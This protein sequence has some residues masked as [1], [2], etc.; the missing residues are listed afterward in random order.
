[1]K[2]AILLLAI[3]A[4]MMG[5]KKQ[6][7]VFEFTIKGTITNQESGKFY[8]SESPRLGD[9]IVIHF[10]NYTF[11]YTGTSPYMYSSLI[12]PDYNLQSVFSFLIEPGE[13]IL[14]LDMESLYEKSGVIS[15]DYNLALYEKQQE[16]MSLFMDRDIM[17]DETRAD[18]FLWM[19]ENTDNFT[20]ISFLN[21]W[22]SFEDFMP[23]DQ[24]G[25]FLNHVTDKQLRN[26]KE[27]I[28]L[29]SMWLAKKDNVNAIGNK[30][31]DFR[32]PNSNGDNVGFRSVSKGKLT[33]VEKSGSWCGNTTANSRNLLPVYEKYKDRGL[34]IITVVPELKHDRWLN[35][36]EKE[37]FPWINL[38]ELD[39]NMA[40]RELSY[41]N[42]IFRGGNYLV[43][44]NGIVIATELSSE[45]LNEI[46]MKHFEPEVYE[47]YLSEKWNMPEK[48]QILDKEQPVGSFDELLEALS[49]KPFLIDCWATWCGP[50]F[51]EFKFNEPLKEFLATMNME[52]VYISFDRPEDESKWL[53]TI[54]EHNLKGYHFRFNDSFRDDFAALGFGGG[55]PTYMI[56]NE[57]G[58]VVVNHAY[59]PSQK[60]KLYSQIE[61]VLK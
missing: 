35:W 22:E 55:L 32:L 1:M 51:E 42:M 44:E 53:N 59:R 29:Y 39:H 57:K 12:F 20:P 49:G 50:C 16:F 11:E 2:K 13:I 31:K 23:V 46:L 9:E 54:R 3:V 37:Q 45:A 60:E 36:I 58:D 33:Y 5:C 25:D 61:R 27:F 28:E 48:I 19:F 21:S 40:K 52:M 15:G 14:E 47:K 41:S 43:D 38:V 17:S 7:Q 26:S 30:A 56:V 18:I 10:E 6:P 24:L 34:E 8:L 4:I